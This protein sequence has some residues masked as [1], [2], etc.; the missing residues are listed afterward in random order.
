MTPEQEYYYNYLKSPEWKKKREYVYQKYNG[1]CIVCGK[2]GT[3]VHHLRYNYNYVTGELDEDL[4][5]D[6]ILL[7]DDHHQSYH[8]IEHLREKTDPEISDKLRCKEAPLKMFVDRFIEFVILKDVAF[9]RNGINFA[10]LKNIDTYLV[11][12]LESCR[13]MAPAYKEIENN[14]G[15]KSI[16]QKYF[17]GIHRVAVL[18]EMAAG[19]TRSALE[20]RYGKSCVSKA[21]KEEAKK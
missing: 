1:K 14:V 19:A 3:Q 9:N 10:D 8:F 17:A 18:Q 7:C 21:L 5:N 11:K 15:W 12:F 13:W 6:L 16:V 2:S 4:D 20:S